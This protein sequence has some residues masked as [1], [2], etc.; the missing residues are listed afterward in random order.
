MTFREQCALM[1]AEKE[2]GYTI[3]LIDKMVELAGDNTSLIAPF[4]ENMMKAILKKTPEAAFKF[5]DA[6]IEESKKEKA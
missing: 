4:A 2:L 6:M 1:Y 3:K 5:A